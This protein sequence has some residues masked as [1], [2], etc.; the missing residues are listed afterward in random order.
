MVP[1]AGIALIL[2]LGEAITPIKNCM[3]I[4]RCFQVSAKLKAIAAGEGTCLC[5]VIEFSLAFS[6]CLQL[7]GLDFNVLPK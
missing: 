1:L 3:F 2:E 7:H 4:K 6:V 5:I